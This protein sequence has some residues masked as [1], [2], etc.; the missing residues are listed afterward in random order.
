MAEPAPPSNTIDPDRL[1][2]RVIAGLFRTYMVASEDTRATLCNEM[3]GRNVAKGHT[4]G[5]LRNGKL[6]RQ[7]FSIV[8]FLVLA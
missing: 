3:I 5:A 7:K 8:R 4:P 1:P 6:F 2:E